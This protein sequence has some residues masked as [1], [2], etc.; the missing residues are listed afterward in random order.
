MKIKS[1]ILPLFAVFALAV[2]P[3]AVASDANGNYTIYGAGRDS[4]AEVLEEHRKDTTRYQIYITWITGFM[5]AAGVYNDIEKVFAADVHGIMH[6]IRDY[7]EKNPLNHLGNA[8]QVVSYQ[9]IDR[10]GRREE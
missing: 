3:V 6:L 7:C 8:A 5:T 10:A 9:L 4:C 1:I 2:S